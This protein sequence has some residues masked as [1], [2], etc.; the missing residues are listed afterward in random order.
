VTLAAVTALLSATMLAAACVPARRA[1]RTN[2]LD[3]FRV[4]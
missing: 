1:A 3:I 2:P 4:A